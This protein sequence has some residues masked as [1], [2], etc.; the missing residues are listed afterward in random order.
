MNRIFVKR[1]KLSLYERHLVMKFNLL[2]DE[3]FKLE[4]YLNN[5]TSP[6]EVEFSDVQFELIKKQKQIVKDHYNII[7]ARLLDFNVVA[8]I[9]S[10]FRLFL[11]NF[12]NG[13]VIIADENLEKATKRYLEEG[14]NESER[15]LKSVEKVNYNCLLDS[16]NEQ[17]TQSN[18]IKDEEDPFKLVKILNS[19]KEP[20]IVESFFV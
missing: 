18:P 3:Y 7:L 1:K 6:K 20:G 12:Q 13:Y 2:K 9:T 15:Y 4:G 8:E 17:F 5:K 11:F 16:L 10:P 19:L 14:K